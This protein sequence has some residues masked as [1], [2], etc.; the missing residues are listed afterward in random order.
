MAFDNASVTAQSSAKTEVELLQIASSKCRATHNTL[1][2]HKVIVQRDLR[3]HL[4][5]F[6]PSA[7]RLVPVHNEPFVQ[8]N[9]KYLNKPN[10]ALDLNKNRKKNNYDTV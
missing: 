2:E 4:G 10:N 3:L 7:N 1:S 6:L 9:S 5:F 8:L